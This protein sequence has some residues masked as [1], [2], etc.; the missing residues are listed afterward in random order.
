MQIRR[1]AVLF[2]ATGGYLGKIPV[3]PGTFGSLAGLPLAW[4]F[5]R[6][7]VGGEVIV[8]VLFIAGAVWVAAEAEL[9][10]GRTDPGAIVIDEIAGMLVTFL[11]IP[12]TAWSV[13]AGFLLFRALDIFKPFPIRYVEKRLAGGIAVV[14]DDLAAGVAANIFLRLLLW[15]V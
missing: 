6:L 11:L 9:L 12:M 2:L 15:L 1:H 4:V 7:P 13:A 5:S 10:L 8:V 14:A 3:A